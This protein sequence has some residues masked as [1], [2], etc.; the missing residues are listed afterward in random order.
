MRDPYLASIRFFPSFLPKAIVILSLF[1]FGA[2]CNSSTGEPGTNDPAEEG[3]SGDVEIVE[4][5]DAYGNIE[6]Y[7]RRLSDYAKEGK[8][9]LIS[10]EGNILETAQYQNDSLHGSRVIYFENGDTQIVEQYQH[11]LFA[12]PYRAYYE[13]G[14]LELS[15]TYTANSMEG[16]WKRYYPSGQLMEEVNFQ[17][18][19]ENGPFTEYH[20][21][22]K[23]KAEG[24]YQDGDNEHGLLKIYDE[25][26]ELA[27][28]MNCQ[29]GVCRTVWEKE[30]SDG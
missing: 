6:R 21:N 23:L 18:N 8:Y 1:F 15:G 5:T 17:D 25:Q 7:A 14:G 9:T 20:E 22:G 27:K 16:V 4:K 2:A 19:Q 28:T 30:G 24:Y 29:H 12:G 3:V 13:E 11:G 26:G 10:P